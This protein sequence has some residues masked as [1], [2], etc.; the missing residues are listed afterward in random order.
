MQRR[1][2]LRSSCK[3]QLPR[4]FASLRMTGGR[5]FWPQLLI[6]EFP[7]HKFTDGFARR[8][9]SL[10]DAMDLGG[11]WHLNLIPLRQ[12]H[13]RIGGLDALRHHPHGANNFRKLA[14]AA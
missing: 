13:G 12:G 4:F 6:L 1:K 2:D 14:P 3:P 11:D 9:L 7:L 5:Q 10:E 8:N